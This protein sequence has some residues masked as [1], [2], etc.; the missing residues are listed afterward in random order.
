MMARGY[1]AARLARTQ[2]LSVKLEGLDPQRPLQ[3]GYAMIF[4]DGRLVRDAARVPDGASI[5]ARV[6]RGTLVARVEGH[7]DE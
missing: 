4:H 2:L 3:R 1:T 6:Q 5:E 7:R